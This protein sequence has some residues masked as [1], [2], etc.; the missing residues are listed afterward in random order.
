MMGRT[1]FLVSTSLMLAAGLAMTPA[2]GQQGSAT[3]DMTAS[4]EAGELGMGVTCAEIND[5]DEAGVSVFL[6]GYQAGVADTMQRAVRADNE[7][8]G[9]EVNDSTEGLKNSGGTVAGE[10]DGAGGGSITGG[11]GGG[12]A[13]GA[14]G[15]PIDQTAVMEGCKADPMSLLSGVIDASAGT[16]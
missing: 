11:A 4:Q 7:E 15:G 1:V 5:M 8:E 14:G 6:S 10:V 16:R 9:V 2:A 12:G 3:V 13:D